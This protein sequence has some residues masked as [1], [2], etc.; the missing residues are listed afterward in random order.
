MRLRPAK[1]GDLAAL[2]ALCLGSKAVWGYDE[3]FLAACVDEL[4][5]GP[6][7]LADS[8][9]MLIEA[10]GPPLAVAQLRVRG[11]EAEIWK[12]FVDPSL[13]G[14][15]LGRR[16]MAWAC[17][18]A[19]GAG[20]VRLRVAADPTAAPFYQRMGAVIIGTAPSMSVKGRDLPLLELRLDGA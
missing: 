7:D 12:M 17:A 14:R 15:G 5:L 13:L 8:D 16:L 18:A 6:A 11:A 9:I 20:A 19:R 3:A 1:A 10:G 4:T 2:S